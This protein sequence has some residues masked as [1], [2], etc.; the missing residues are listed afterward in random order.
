MPITAAWSPL[1]TESSSASSGISE[2]DC[3]LETFLLREC[4]ESMKRRLMHHILSPG[5]LAMKSMNFSLAIL[6]AMPLRRHSALVT[7]DISSFSSR[8]FMS[9]MMLPTPNLSFLVFSTSTVSC[10]VADRFMIQKFAVSPMSH[11]M[12]FWLMS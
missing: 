10:M 8:A 6:N 11:R 9:P 4:T 2:M 5:F 7:T 3:L 12:S 1:T